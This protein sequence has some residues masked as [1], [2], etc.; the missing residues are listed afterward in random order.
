MVDTLQEFNSGHALRF[1]NILYTLYRFTHWRQYKMAQRLFM[2]LTHFH[3]LNNGIFES[4][5]TE[6]SFG[7]SN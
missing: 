5:F 1:L 2:F 6:V 7:G 4:A 3:E